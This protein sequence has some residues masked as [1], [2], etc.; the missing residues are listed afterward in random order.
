MEECSG[1]GL[2]CRDTLNLMKHMN[3][4]P[5]CRPQ[6]RAQAVVQRRAE[7]QVGHK[8]PR[9]CETRPPAEAERGLVGRGLP[10]CDAPP[11]MPLRF[12]LLDPVEAFGNER[13]WA[14]FMHTLHTGGFSHEA[15]AV[16]IAHELTTTS[17]VPPLLLEARDGLRK[18]Y[19]I[20]D[21]IAEQLG[22]NFTEHRV[23]IGLTIGV[24]KLEFIG[25]DGD[26]HM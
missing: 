19:K 21:G 23:R 5:S 26:M 17:P 13:T 22:L 12:A 6:D 1:C 25:A 14:F 15:A 8:R 4:C 2:Q 9:P 10:V 16:A 3:Q 7:K 20:A 11:L 18:G 24:Q